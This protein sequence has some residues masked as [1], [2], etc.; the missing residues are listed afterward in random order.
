MTL[1]VLAGIPIIAIAGF[2][3]SKTLQSK[4]KFLHEIYSKA[5]GFVEQAIFQIKTVKQLQGE[6]H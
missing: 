3:Y 4:G 6:E 5:G 1:V 2:L